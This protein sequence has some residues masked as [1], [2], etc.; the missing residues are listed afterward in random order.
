MDAPLLWFL[1]GG[2]LLY[3][4][5]EIQFLKG[6]V[7]ALSEALRSMGGALDPLIQTYQGNRRDLEEI[8]SLI[9]KAIK[10]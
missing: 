2:A 9:E 4:F 1:A 8:R 3:L 10:E 7:D 6:R 5:I